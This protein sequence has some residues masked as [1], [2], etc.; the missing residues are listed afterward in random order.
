MSNLYPIGVI[1]SPVDERDFNYNMVAGATEGITIP[2]GFKLPYQFDMSQVNQGQTNMCVSFAMCINKE[3]RTKS[4]KRFA[5]LSIYG[6]RSVGD[7]QGYGLV[8]RQAAAHEVNDGVC[9]LE[10]LP[11]IIDIPKATQIFNDNKTVYLQKMNLHKTKAYFNVN[12]EDIKRYVYTEQAPLLITIPV[13][14]SVYNTNKGKITSY[15]GQY[16][17]GHAITL[18][19]WTKDSWIFL[20]SWGTSWGDNAVGYLN[21]NLQINEILGFD[22]T[23]KFSNVTIPTG[24][25]LYKVQCGGSFTTSKLAHDYLNK[26]LQTKISA[27]INYNTS[28]SLYTIQCGAYKNKDNAIVMQN[29]LITAGFKNA[30]I[31]EIQK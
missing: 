5:P 12:V 30:I 9:Y 15:S 22:E 14:D 13:Y 11:F 18:I 2:D 29:K 21:F 24:Y 28:T 7:Y 19:G 25:I 31:T 23:E 26:I 20:N 6:N 3:I 16:Y 17:G 10:D 27:C 1:D 8:A 4:P